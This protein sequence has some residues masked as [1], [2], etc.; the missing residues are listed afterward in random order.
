VAAHR[1]HPPDRQNRRTHM[2]TLD[3]IT[4][5]TL[6]SLIKLIDDKKFIVE[7]HG[8]LNP[9]SGA[10][11]VLVGGADGDLILDG[12]LIDIKT[13][14][15][16]AMKRAI[17]DQLIGYFILLKVGDMYEL[18]RHSVYFARFEEL[19]NISI[20]ELFKNRDI[21]ADAKDFEKLIL[22]CRSL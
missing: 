15:S 19:W 18:D 3:L 7:R 22:S 21:V 4:S 12:N 6:R 2:K 5:Q 9:T 1:V 20:E 8:I 13:T 16:L 10:G 17:F 14:K 11:S